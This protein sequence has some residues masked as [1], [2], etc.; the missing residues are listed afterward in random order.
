MPKILGEPLANRDKIIDGKF[1][2]VFTD[3][4]LV[5]LLDGGSAAPCRPSRGGSP[6]LALPIGPD[7]QAIDSSA[8][9]ETSI[10]IKHGDAIGGRA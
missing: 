3:I 4:S 8:S 2:L 5:D 6:I 9:R 10:H 7:F 1:D